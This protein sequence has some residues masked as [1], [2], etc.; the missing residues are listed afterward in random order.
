[1]PIQKYKPEGFDGAEPAYSHSAV[2]KALLTGQIIE[3]RAVRCDSDGNLTVSLGKYT[4]II[5]RYLSAA[6]AKK[7]EQKNCRG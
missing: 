4:G 7:G 6:G 1:M 3:G 2:E 5:P